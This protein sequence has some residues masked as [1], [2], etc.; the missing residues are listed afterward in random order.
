MH[1]FIIDVDNTLV[2]LKKL[3]NKYLEGCVETN[4][5]GPLETRYGF[6]NPKKGAIVL[7]N[8]LIQAGFN[9]IFLTARNGT[10]VCRKI[11]LRQIRQCL[12]LESINLFMR[13]PGDNRPDVEIKKEIYAANL[14]ELNCV[15]AVDDRLPVIKMWVDLGLS[16]IIIY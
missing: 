1:S 12:G 7:I 8:Q 13:R 16:V 14:S 3:E 6:C 11:T 10:K 2:D 5:W 9:P 4:N 15:L